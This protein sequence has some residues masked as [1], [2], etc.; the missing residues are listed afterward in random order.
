M[1]D[2][3]GYLVSTRCA[4]MHQ[5]RATS[6]NAIVATGLAHAAQRGKITFPRAAWE[7]GRA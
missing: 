2:A 4:V 5:G 6:N 3:K 1:M 7:R